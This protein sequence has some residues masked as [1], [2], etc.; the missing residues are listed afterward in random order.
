MIL[1]GVY[2]AT[3]RYSSYMF[4]GRQYEPDDLDNSIGSISDLQEASLPSSNGSVSSSYLSVPTTS[5]EG[6]GSLRSIS[7]EEEL[8]ESVFDTSKDEDTF[9]TSLGTKVSKFK[10]K[11]KSKNF[12]PC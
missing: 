3:F 8:V 10:G 11:K 7:L 2:D 12:F 6:S 5:S 1:T 9:D 4:V